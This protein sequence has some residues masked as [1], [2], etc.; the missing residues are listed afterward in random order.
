MRAQKDPDLGIL[1]GKVA[2]LIGIN[3]EL[4][5]PKFK[6]EADRVYYRRVWEKFKTDQLLQSITILNLAR[7]DM[8]SIPDQV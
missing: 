8:H 6:E 3:L 2:S 1:V 7:M 5:L 4:E